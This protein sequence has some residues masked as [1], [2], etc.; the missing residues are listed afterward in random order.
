MI[1]NECAILIDEVTILIYTFPRPGAEDAA[2]TKIAASIE[3]TW[4]HV[5]RLKTV[6]VASHRF[7]GEKEA[8][9]FSADALGGLVMYP[10]GVIPFGM[11]GKDTTSVHAQ[12]LKNELTEMPTSGEAATVKATRLNPPS[13]DIPEGC[14]ESYCDVML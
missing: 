11:H 4:K 1:N 9:Q 6:I 5:G 7:A 8:F 12:D 2:F 14:Q 3:R 13:T 10:D